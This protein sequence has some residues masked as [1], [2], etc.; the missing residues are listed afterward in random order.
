[1]PDLNGYALAKRIRHEAWGKHIALIAL[2]GWAKSQTSDARSRQ[3][4]II[5]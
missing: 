1:M 3:D 5:I 2:T 4:S